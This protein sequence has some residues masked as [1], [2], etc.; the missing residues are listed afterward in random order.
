MTANFSSISLS[1]Y[2]AKFLRGFLKMSFCVLLFSLASCAKKN[3]ETVL[4][5]IV[6]LNGET[7]QVETRV[8]ELNARILQSQGQQV[9]Q[10]IPNN[11]E[12]TAVAVNSSEN[13]DLQQTLQSEQAKP[14]YNV[15]KNEAQQNNFKVI[16]KS[17][18]AT[19]IGSISEKEQE[20]QYDLSDSNAA[21][22]KDKQPKKKMRLKEGKTAVNAGKIVEV[23]D[24]EE[25]VKKLKKGKKEIFVQTGSFSNEANA[26]QDLKAVKKFF[27]AE[28]EEAEVGDKTIYRVLLGPFKTDVKAKEM[29]RKVKA[30]GHDAIVVKR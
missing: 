5:R 13:S 1:V 27:K 28:I 15:A 12:N 17:D 25:P 19:S 14:S 4:F 6:G 24:A 2:V 3:N 22:S 20:I 26:E 18:E 8:P 21:K 10:T 9:T 7:R 11:P 16:E 30:S 23:E 29:V